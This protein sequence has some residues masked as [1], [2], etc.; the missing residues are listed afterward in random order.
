MWEFIA[1]SFFLFVKRT[2]AGDECAYVRAR[3]ALA[4]HAVPRRLRAGS[5]GERPGRFCSQIRCVRR[6]EADFCCDGWADSHR[7]ESGLYPVLTVH[8][9]PSMRHT[10]TRYNLIRRSSLR[11]SPAREEAAKKRVGN[12]PRRPDCHRMAGR[13]CLLTAAACP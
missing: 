7:L 13:F 4:G 11:S 3:C 2:H 5:E 1:S 9:F 10:M 6:S 12:C 8:P